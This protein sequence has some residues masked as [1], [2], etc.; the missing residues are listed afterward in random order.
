M[1]VAA[2]PARAQEAPDRQEAT[3]PERVPATL[4]AW[5][6]RIDGP[7]G[8]STVRPVK[9]FND[10]R[11]EWQGW[12]LQG[13][14]VIASGTLN[15]GDCRAVFEAAREACNHLPFGQQLTGRGT[16][17]APLYKLRLS[18][19]SRAI[20]LWMDYGFPMKAEFQE[21]FYRGMNVVDRVLS[22]NQSRNRWDFDRFG[23]SRTG[24]PDPAR[25]QIP[26]DPLG[27]SRIY[28]RYSAPEGEVR[29]SLTLAKNDTNDADAPRGRSAWPPTLSIRETSGSPL[30]RTTKREVRS[31][32]AVAQY[33]EDARMLI[34][35]FR[36]Q[37]P[38][39]GEVEGKATCD[40]GID[41][42][43][44]GL[45]VEFK[46]NEALP[47]EWRTRVSRIV[48]LGRRKEL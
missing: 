31:P 14:P 2:L 4:S 25:N 9:V 17:D 29:I 39:P 40:V 15:E 3:P 45:Q 18:S 46:V 32:E 11:Y 44:R 8:P 23:P 38:K 21:P 36:L 47:E 24:L 34:N 7:G 41:A 5:Q 48:E 19:G 26:A 16:D 20:A 12:N 27:L 35:E 43:N 30:D 28:F 13:D 6:I 37:D 10:G 42:P 33:Y 1:V 22:A